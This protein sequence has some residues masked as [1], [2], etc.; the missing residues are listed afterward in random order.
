MTNSRFE[1][2][3]RRCLKIK[4]KRIAKIVFICILLSLVGFGYFYTTVK[5][6]SSTLASPIESVDKKNSSILVPE[7]TNVTVK[8]LN[9]TVTQ[10]IKVEEN[11]SKNIEEKQ[12]ESLVSYD[13][14]MLSPKMTL[15]PSQKKS[16]PSEEKIN[17]AP[18]SKALAKETIGEMED[19]LG[20]PESKKPLSI[21]VTSLSNE[22]ALLKNFHS[23]KS[24]SEALALA[25]FYFDRQEY[26]KAISWAKES[27]KLK[28]VSDEPWLLYAKSKFHLGDRAEAIRSLE[29]FLGYVNSKEVKD[30]LLFYKGQQ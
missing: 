16:P 17:L 14:L 7:D 19:F 9:V 15:N 8:E 29:L 3:E 22:E 25:H 11:S 27:S 10:A 24:F 5:P 12:D 18:P 4:R 13:T 21:S 2:L 23:S 20:K 6:L 28:P 1:D 26:V 30:L